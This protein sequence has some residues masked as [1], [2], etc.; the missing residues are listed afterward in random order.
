MAAATLTRDNIVT[1]CRKRWA[2]DPSLSIMELHREAVARGYTQS[3]ETLNRKLAGQRPEVQEHPQATALTHAVFDATMARAMAE[4]ALAQ[5]VADQ[6]TA[7]RAAMAAGISPT[8]IAAMSG[9]S[10]PRLYQIKEFRR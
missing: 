5:A 6:S 3:Y 4:Q 8:E 9:L 2:K 7:I 10:V 1:H